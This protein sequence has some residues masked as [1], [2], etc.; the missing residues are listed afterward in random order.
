[1][2]KEENF[3]VSIVGMVILILTVIVMFS[4]CKDNPVQPQ[5]E[6][7]NLVIGEPYLYLSTKNN[8]TDSFIIEYLGFI[9]SPENVLREQIKITFL[10]KEPVKYWWNQ[11][12][13]DITAPL[14]I[15]Q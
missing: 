10:G 3:I 7:I 1:M 12:G 9:I 11:Y 5:T 13:T 14:G 2:K 6:G 4:G 15:Y 8:V